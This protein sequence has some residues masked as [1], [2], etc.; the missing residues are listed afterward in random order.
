VPVAYMFGK[1]TRRPWRT[2]APVNQL[3]VPPA[4]A[5]GAVV[6]VD[7]LISSTP[8]FVGQMRGSLTLQRY[9]VSTIFIDHFS[10][11]S[12]VHNQLSTAAAHTIE[13]KRAFERFTK[14]HGV[15]VRHYHADNHIF[16]SDAFITEIHSCGQSILYSGDNA[17]H[18]NGRAEKKIRD[19][20]ELVRTMLLHAWQR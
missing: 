14:V 12:Y 1:A 3:Q 10:R 13:A 5:P 6:S 18:Q 17:H 4:T 19:L 9:K 16:D 2:R 20:Q 8:G 11:L 7:Q 15:L